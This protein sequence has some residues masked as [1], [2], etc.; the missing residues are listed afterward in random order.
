MKGW[1]LGFGTF[2]ALGAT[3]SGTGCS[4]KEKKFE[5]VCQVVAKRVVE[6]SDDGKP[7]LVDLELEWDPCPG[8]QFQIV[9]GSAEFAQCT[10]KYEVG[11][12]VPVRVK[13]WWDE[14]GYYRWDIYQVGDCTR[15]IEP[16]S[17]GSYEK[18]QE[19]SE[20]KAYGHVTGFDCMRRPEKKLV[21][22]CPWMARK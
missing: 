3:W 15:D 9:R 14:R 10:T 4:A 17:E 12:Y 2:L 13:Q 5:S 6:T 8:D 22:V 16:E 1:V 7:E 19:C 20:V 18:S 11:Q 21:S